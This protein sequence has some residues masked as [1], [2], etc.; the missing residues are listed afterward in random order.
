MKTRDIEQ[1]EENPTLRRLQERYGYLPARGATY[2]KIM[3]PSSW[4][5]S[6]TTHIPSRLPLRPR[7]DGLST[8][9][10]V[11][12]LASA[13][14]PQDSEPSPGRRTLLC[15][16]RSSCRCPLCFLNCLHHLAELICETLP[17]RFSSLPKFF[18]AD[19][20]L[21]SAYLICSQVLSFV[22]NHLGA[23]HVIFQ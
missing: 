21:L 23:G 13:Q 10:L 12:D 22:Y 4:L 11:P 6:S 7:C 2:Q 1:P 18:H 3:L 8:S 16:H 14:C 19:H 17:F 5:L 20:S 15:A 9:W